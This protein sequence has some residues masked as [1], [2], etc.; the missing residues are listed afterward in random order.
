MAALCSR[1][2]AGAETL[3]VP[4]RGSAPAMQDTL[5]GRHAFQIDTPGQQQ[6]LH[7]PPAGCASS[8]S[9]LTNAWPVA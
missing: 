7:R 2:R 9:A 4:Y 6:G 1:Q 3:H 5:A 8:P